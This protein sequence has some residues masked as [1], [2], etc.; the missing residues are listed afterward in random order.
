MLLF[1]IFIS[2][3]LKTEINLISITNVVHKMQIQCTEIK[4]KSLNI[5]SINLIVFFYC[6]RSYGSQ[7]TLEIFRRNPSRNGSVPSVKRLSMPLAT[8][9]T[10]GSTSI[11]P[12]TSC[13]NLVQQQRRPST[14]CSTNTVSVEYNR[15]KLH[16]PQV[17]FSA[18]VGS[19]V[20]V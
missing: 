12:V 7:L 20:I 14:V 16:L 10:L 8:S 11:L 3:V 15:R 6:Y 2:Y 13:S 18:E 5:P 4:I 17:T 1:K 9:T 19:G